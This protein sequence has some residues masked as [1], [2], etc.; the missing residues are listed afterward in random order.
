MVAVAEAFSIDR[1]LAGWPSTPPAS[2]G[3]WTKREKAWRDV[4]ADLTAATS[5]LPL[6]GYVEVR[7]ALQYG[8]GPVTGQQLVRGD[9]PLSRI[10]AW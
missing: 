6:M 5:W 4:G 1:L 7:N 8:L 2:T 10:A 3:T 9:Q